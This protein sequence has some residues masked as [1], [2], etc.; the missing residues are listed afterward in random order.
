MPRVNLEDTSYER[1][2]RY[3][4]DDLAEIVEKNYLPMTPEQLLKL[5]G[6]LDNSGSLDG[7]VG[8]FHHDLEYM[9]VNYARFI[10]GKEKKRDMSMRATQGWQIVD[11]LLADGVGEWETA[12]QDDGLTLSDVD[13]LKAEREFADS[14]IMRLTDDAEGTAELVTTLLVRSACATFAS[15]TVN[16]DDAMLADVPAVVSGLAKAEAWLREGED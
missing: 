8:R 15:L 12:S 1:I 16:W 2:L 4:K 6:T 3:D 13:I 9:L 14:I 5:L 7:M 10:S 11:D